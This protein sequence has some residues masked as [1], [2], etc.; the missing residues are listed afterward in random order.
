[1]KNLDKRIEKLEEQQPPAA[2]GP[3]TWKEFVEWS[4]AGRTIP[5]LGIIDMALRP[6]IVEMGSEEMSENEFNRRYPN[7][8]IVRIVD[9]DKDHEGLTEKIG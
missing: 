4:K 3:R 2:D 1:M 8:V 7:G 5:G 9:E 6:G